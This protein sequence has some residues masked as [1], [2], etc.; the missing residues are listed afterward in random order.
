MIALIEQHPELSDWSF[1]L[2]LVAFVLALVLLAL[3]HRSRATDGHT[4]GHG[5]LVVPL[6]YVGLAL[7][8][9]GLLVL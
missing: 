3:D 9:L 6:S 5:S 8:A 1:L 7:V 4:G 2:A